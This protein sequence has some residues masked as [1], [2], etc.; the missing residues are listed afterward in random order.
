MTAAE[1]TAPKNSGAQPTQTS[2]HTGL[3]IGALVVSAMVMI[4]NE[5]ILSV[6]LP[7]IMADFNVGADLAQWL[8]T[9]FMLTMAV[10]IP[11]TGFLMQRFSTRTLFLAALTFFTLGTV[12]GALAPT[13]GVLLLARVVQAIGTAMI[14]P[15][16]MTVALTVVAPERRGVMMG[17]ISVV[18]SVAPA[19]GPTISGIILSSFTWHWLFWMMVPISLICLVVGGLVIRNVAEP[20]PA[21]FDVASVILS[22]LAFGGLVYALSSISAM[23]AGGSLIPLAALIVGLLALAA[24]VYRQ[25]V[26]QRSDRALLSMNP[27]RSRTFTLSVITVVGAFGTMLGTVT[28]LPIY[29]QQ[30]LHLSAMTTGMMMLPGGLVQAA[31]SPAIGRLYDRVGPRPLAIPGTVLM[32]AAQIA[33]FLGLNETTSIGYIIVVHVVFSVGMALVMTSLMTASLASL[34]MKEYGHGSAILNTLQQL[35]GAAGT[36]GFIAAMTLGGTVAPAFV[37]GICAVSVALIAAL[38]IR[39]AARS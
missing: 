30:T 18:I 17:I 12:V 34:P 16:L 15:L 4:L 39:P 2:K 26:L 31:L 33:L 20:R 35:G 25:I 9:G 10:V 24:F 38:F 21:P 32:L 28:V 23:L 14:M 6:A 11:T 3:L 1:S 8:T 5:T 29:L 22:A 13:F 7:S 19:I 36:A 27:F 37:V